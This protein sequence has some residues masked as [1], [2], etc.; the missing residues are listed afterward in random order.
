MLSQKQQPIYYHNFDNFIDVVSVLFNNADTY[1][2][3]KA[4]LTRIN[5]CMC[6]RACVCVCVCVE[7]WWNDSDREKPKHLE[8][9]LFQYHFV[10]NPTL[11]NL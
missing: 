5:V 3:H 10:R 1:L 11:T 9:H 4:S 6:V 8:E 2:V 7:H